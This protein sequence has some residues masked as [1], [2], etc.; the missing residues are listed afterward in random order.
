MASFTAC[1]KKVSLDPADKAE[2][3]ARARRHRAD[4]VAPS[5]AAKR[6]VR[7][8]IIELRGVQREA[9]LA[10]SP[11]ASPAPSPA[12]PTERRHPS[13]VMGSRLLA[14]VSRRLG[15]L[16]PAWLSE[17][18]TRF[19][20]ARKGK[21]GRPVVQ[22]RN[23]MVP[24]IGK[25]FR[26]G[27]TQDLQRIAEVMEEEGFLSPGTVDADAKAAGEQAKALIQKALNRE[28][29]KSLDEQAAEAQTAQDAER[30]AYYEGLD[31]EAAREAEAEREAIMAESEAKVDGIDHLAD[32][33]MVP[34]ELAEPSSLQQTAD[35]LGIT[36]E[37][38]RRE[39]GLQG[40]L[41]QDEQAA[42]GGGES[43]RAHA[44]RAAQPP[45]EARSA[46][47]QRGPE[48]GQEARGLTLEAQTPAD[49]EAKAEREAAGTAAEQARRKVD[50]QRL[51]RQADERDTR[52]RVDQTVGDFQLGQSAEQ[53]LSGTN[54]LF[55]AKPN[56][57]FTED[58]AE[59]ARAILRRKLGQINSGID[60]ELV[61]AGITLAGY[62][63]ERGARSFAAYA[64]AMLAD[65]GE[66][67]RPYLKSWYM[68]AKYDPRLSGME[69]TSGA[70][71]VEAADINT[72]P[73]QNAAQETPD[74]PGA[75][76]DLER[77]RQNAGTGNAAVEG[78]VPG[79]EPAGGAS[80][81]GGRDG[82]SGRG[83]PDDQG[84]SD[85]GTVLPREPGDQ[86]V[87]RADRADGPAE[88]PART[89]DGHRSDDPGF[90]RPATGPRPTGQAAQPAA[91]LPNEERAAAQRAAERI[92]PVAGDL[93]NIRATLPYLL[94]GQQEDVH[95]AE[96]RHLLPG[97][98]GY[99]LTNGTG[100]GKTFSGLG[101]I[102]RFQREGKTDTLIVVPDEKIMA[103]WVASGLPMG[104]TIT[105]LKDTKDG[106]A[107]ITITTYANLG[108]NLE[109]ARRKWDLIVPDE[110][111][112]LMQGADGEGTLAIDALR[113]I[114]M[115]PRGSITRFRMLHHDELQRQRILNE[116]LEG[117][118]RI[119]NNPDTMDQVLAD[120]RAENAKLD[121]EL[122]ALA[123]KLAAAR[124]AVQAEV[125]AAQG[126]GRTRVLALS[127]TPFAYEKTIDWAEGYL[128]SY[129][130]PST[131][132]RS[133]NRGDA[134]EQ[135]FVQH[136]G[137]RMRNNKL[138]EPDAGVD[139]GLMQRQFNTW[140]K[141]EGA[142]SGRMLEVDADYDRRFVMVDSAVG[143]QIDQAIEFIN[144]QRK[145]FDEAQPKDQQAPNGWAFLVGDLNEAL[146]GKLGH[147]TRRYL[148]EA[149]KAK[150]VIPHIR[151]HLALGRKVV[152][153]HD[154]KKGGAVNP[155]AF[156][157]RTL[158]P[159]GQTEMGPEDYAKAQADVAAHN[160]A[161]RAFRERFPDLAG[162]D[163][164]NELIPPVERF[165]REFPDVLLINGDE[166][167]A[168][169]LARYQRFQ[170]D[171]AGPTIALVQS[172]KNKGWS[173]HDTTGKHQRVLFNLGL[174]TQPTKT[175]QQE[176]RIYRTGQVSNAMFRYL[177]TGTNW[178][179]WA[180]AQTIAERASAAE[181]L[182]MG[183]SARAL[184]DAYIAAFEESGDFRAGHE[185]EGT[186]GKARDAL[187]NNALTDYDRAKSFY[188]GTQKKDA[189]TK[190]QEG[191]D[192][193]A[194]PEPLGLKM[195]EWADVRAGEDALEPSAGHGAIARW[196]PETASRTA[197]E[198]SNALGSRL[199]L[200]FDGKIVR[201]EFEG[202]NV[203]NKYD[204]IVM[205]PPFGTGGKTA[206][207]HL[208]KAATHLRD[209]GR[210]VALI[211][212]GPAADKRFEQWFH[213]EQER[214]VKP[215]GIVTL[216][217]RQTPI[218][219][220]DT[221]TSRAAWAPEG[222]V[223]GW[224]DGAP[225]VKASAPEFRGAGASLVAEPAILSVQPTGTRTEKFSATEGLHLV[226]DIKLP[227]VTFER[228]GTKVATRVVVIEKPGRDRQAP[229]QVNRDL[230]DIDTIGGLFDALEPMTLAPRAKPAQP[231]AARVE[232]VPERAQAQAASADLAHQ[233]GIKLV[234]HTTAKGK[235]LKGVIRKNLTRQQ[236]EQVDPYTFRKDGGFFIRAEHL[237][238]LQ[239]QFPA[240]QPLLSRAADAARGMP[241]QDLRRMVDRV[242]AGW[243]DGGPTVTVVTTVQ[244][245]PPAI[246]NALRSKNALGNTRGL[247]LPDGRVYLVA[248]RFNSMAE[249]QAVLFHEVYGHEGL[250][251]FLGD[252]YI[253][254]M[255]LL[256]AANPKLRGEAE[257]WFRDNGRDEIA[258][259][260]ARGMSQ[261]EAEA[262]VRAIAVEEALSDRA[263]DNPPPN[264]WKT[265]MSRLQ[266][267][268]R[269]RGL[270][271]IADKLESMTEAE[272][273]AVLMGARR[274]IDKQQGDLPGWLQDG[275]LRSTD[276]NTPAD[277]VRAFRDTERAYGG[278]AAH[279]QALAAG[280]TRLPYSQWVQ[281][282]T[283]A[284][285]A[286]FGD[287]EAARA[288]DRLDAMAPVAL[289]LPEHLRG[290]S[291]VQLRD[292]VKA[293][294]DAM[295]DANTT[296]HHPVLG[297]V[298]FSKGNNKKAVSTSAT[299]EKLQAAHEIVSVIESGIHAASALSTAPNEAPHGV[300]YHTLATKVEAF[301]REFVALV[302]VKQ[303]PNGQRFYNNIAV[304]PAN[305]KAPAAYPG[306]RAPGDVGSAAA[307]AGAD[308]SVLPAMRRV[309]PETVS[310]ATDPATG[311]PRVMFHGT[312]ADFDRFKGKQAEAIFLTDEPIFAQAYADTSAKWMQ[313][314]E[315][316]G[317]ARIMP[318]FASAKSPFD[319]QNAKHRARVIEIAL[320]QNGGKNGAGETVIAND[321]GT[322][323]LW[324]APVIESG[325]TEPAGDGNWLL[326]EQPWMQD[327]IKAAGF[328]A[329]YVSESGFKNLALYESAQVKSAV[330]NRGTFD[331]NEAS[332]L[333]S[334]KPPADPVLASAMRKAG[335][336][337]RPTLR[338]KVSRFLT[339]W[340]DL[341]RDR[342]ALADEVRQGTLDQFYGIQRAVR[343]ELGNLPMEQ[344]PYITARLAN[345]GASSVMRGLLL[346]GQA[347]WAANGQHLEKIDGTQGLLDILK[348]LG[349]DLDHFFG[350]MVGNR[351][352]RLKAEG[353]ENNL[354]DAEIKAL[355]ALATPERLAKFQQAAQ[356]Y[357]QFKRS[358]LDVAQEAG[359]IDPE[360]RK[361]WDHADYIP[362]YR[363]I[364]AKAV[365]SPTGHKGLAGQSSGIRTLKGGESML[366]DPMENLLMNFSR[367]IDA[368]LKNNAIRKTIYALENQSDLVERVGYDMAPALVPRSQV[369]TMLRKAGTPEAVLQA[370]PA[371]VFDG[372]GKMWA[373]RAPSD[374]DVV[375]VM[376]GG[377]PV[378]FRVH[379]PLLL[380]SLTSF[381]P[382][383]FPMS[384]VFRGA[385]R[386]LTAMVTSTPEFMARNWIR[387]SL[388]AQAITNTPFNPLESVKGIWKAYKENQAYEAMLFAGA[389]FQSGNVNAGDPQGTAVGMRRALR[390]R[391]FDASSIDSFM[392]SIID[393]T[394]RGWEK[395]REVGEAVE[396]ANRN[397]IYEAAVGSG[398]SATAAAFEAKDLMDF[399]LRGDWAGYQ[400][401]A[402]VLPFFNARVQGL[403]RLGRA[404]PKRLMA[405]GMLM[406]AATAML[407]LANAGE[408]WYERLPDWDKDTFWHVKVGGV[409]LR[410]PKPFELGVLFATLPERIA[411][412]VLGYDSAKKT[413]SRVYSNVRDQLSINPMPQAIRPATEAWANWDSFRGRPIE[414]MADEGLS[415]HAR[416]DAR[417]SD[418]MR[419]LANAA[420][421]VTDWA[422]LSPKKLEFLINGYFGTVGMYA[423]GVSDAMV[424]SIEGRPARPAWRMDDIPVIRAFYAEDPPKATVFESDIYQMRGEV[425][426]IMKEFRKGA[427]SRIP[428]EQQAAKDLLT[429]ESD[430]I[431]AYGIV[432][433]VA[434]QVSSINKR[435]S[436]IYLDP[437]LDAGQKRV[438]VDKLLTK[439]AAI[440]QQAAQNP[441]VRA[442]F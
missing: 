7:D 392:G 382:Y 111:H 223:T 43:D 106:G 156:A 6:A 89:G 416:F 163:L 172:D 38:L 139:R 405:V 166:K 146:Y 16:D 75:H 33:D 384:S 162:G 423:M 196:L 40:P 31:A 50:Q 383:D 258:A 53:Q 173:G 291:L 298:G 222:V 59:K 21:D 427:Q 390:E 317:A 421:S 216:D 160:E 184:K 257:A 403:Y 41:R 99:L 168:D 34:W 182:G 48:D 249:A 418:T 411:R 19:E 164:L 186:G 415:P 230:S 394:A 433:G 372:I 297:E 243:R 205:N 97:G 104:L 70:A 200:V 437:N 245:L 355:Q 47:P 192:Y 207:E 233:Q 225:L 14:V 253:T 339:R 351:A 224:R 2:V 73:A 62:H 87:H 301:G 432:V 396:N 126:A 379:D 64:R 319:Y 398:K 191:K 296:A 264:A 369:E 326:V 121:A 180:F 206:I 140:L 144:D 85:G 93:A 109:L 91:G 214:P 120:V 1:L 56:T 333:L 221:V 321:D 400:I 284:F 108:Q 44:G 266:A 335:I 250:R 155:F 303:T 161:V 307:F 74:V 20:T 169:L 371:D 110:A 314:R 302:T 238:K 255:A 315:Q 88:F 357:A 254:T 202:H 86:P 78:A 338:G 187:A 426:K 209:G 344:D 256:R 318:M 422:G 347:K 25:L 79:E 359:L 198:P 286:W 10:A 151:E 334:R 61:Q 102:K 397:A 76:P 142:L 378:F 82:S 313:H 280:R 377:K 189:R 114:S 175:I 27:G 346:H 259:R 96:T 208:E 399:N 190:A 49:L 435:I 277:T 116:R 401:L 327:A 107:G 157:E 220:G 345:G 348:P 353:R 143:N 28:E 231:V 51:Q 237:P 240:D 122:T 105:P 386:L 22:W 30:Q 37:E 429:K 17:F 24:G 263:G 228:A 246:V 358:V 330:G 229:Q 261:K 316:D 278:R 349:D 252:E 404:D 267:A 236:A 227:A 273:H 410:I 147:L 251:A 123:D 203:V 376:M 408:D 130:E 95:K 304:Q 354:S 441:S 350:W 211:P 364:D 176:G 368:S 195:A 289:A 167:K 283:P 23:P 381:V 101:T 375:R 72:I 360:G 57:I 370:M 119:L 52:A 409:H 343:S 136:F 103:D 287:W 35:F 185:G 363:E 402:D 32:D 154:F 420:P 331:P 137:Y 438:E 80:A 295:A 158:P 241:A 367:L 128:F 118:T 279:A 179:R 177:N 387:D 413:I 366:N 268:L 282:R 436:D 434:K 442:V 325:L 210:I 46:A 395:Y 285:K 165:K 310:K 3:M 148:L 112:Q 127:A 39:Q 239:E 218:Y 365:F 42:A 274:A 125:E 328:D 71:E 414:N 265:L 197:I 63:I 324:S 393:N 29:V 65:M 380:R 149:I 26:Q 329:F 67:V 312:G 94:P 60:P 271:W 98:Y 322:P 129:G 13:T 5:E 308:G 288:Q 320:A 270:G 117:N 174:P 100:T 213:G 131:E 193:F 356:Q 440:A 194:T 305:E 141:R 234:E 77:D 150:E 340:R 45:P 352:A 204:A 152:V 171:E 83:R 361:A 4:G 115:H 293:R 145:A 90:E 272:T 8:L 124:K 332:I 269:K 412:G 311:E 417:T 132:G 55:E 235:L 69:G 276:P 374:P 406:T 201:G 431:K 159:R 323:S 242:S 260:V 309:N 199:A 281:V 292:A 219:K 262:V 54:D 181:N 391:G 84:V 66:L 11:A 430:K 389:S 336:N 306:D 212:T 81:A 275:L 290:A 138:T 248:D 15:G 36:I 217:G 247:R 244:D 385:R 68:A 439:K 294:L 133:Y 425:E 12:A 170:S 341:T 178:E 153:F 232:K 134:R 18:S 342:K 419:V 135:F 58:A 113:A 183:E 428:S 226:A 188:F 215:L 407:A 299:P 373:I 300:T 9:K 388:A 337:G 362:F 92:A 424:R